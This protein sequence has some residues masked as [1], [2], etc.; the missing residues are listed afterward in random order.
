MPHLVIWADKSGTRL[1]RD[2]TGTT[3]LGDQRVMNTCARLHLIDKLEPAFS[4]WDF[5]IS[6]LYYRSQ[7]IKRGMLSNGK[8][9]VH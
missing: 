4:A 6:V 2:A 3:A 1:T 8:T 5:S 9:K 7:D